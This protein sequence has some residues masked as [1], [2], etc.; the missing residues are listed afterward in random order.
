M[1]NEQMKSSNQKGKDAKQKSKRRCLPC[2]SLNSGR[3]SINDAR[4]THVPLARRAPEAVVMAVSA[5]L[6][7]L[8]PYVLSVLV[9]MLLLLAHHLLLLLL[10]DL[11]TH[12]LHLLLLACWVKAAVRVGADAEVPPVEIFDPDRA[13]VGVRCGCILAVM[14]GRKASTAG[15]GASC[16]LQVLKTASEDLFT[17]DFIH[18][19]SCR[20]VITYLSLNNGPFVASALSER[21]PDLTAHGHVLL[22]QSLE[23]E[24]I[25]VLRVAAV[26][27]PLMALA[28]RVGSF[29]GEIRVLD[30]SPV[31]ALGARRHESDVVGWGPGAGGRAGGDGDRGGLDVLGC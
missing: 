30:L 2:H 22:S 1:K 29:G 31:L 8:S 18:S 5:S 12:H 25:P 27:E 14:R 28:A 19:N 13:I 11:C 6:H 17:L 24:R 10:V 23:L 3:S 15:R 16:G 21:T 4:D 9:M 7:D 20:S 26:H